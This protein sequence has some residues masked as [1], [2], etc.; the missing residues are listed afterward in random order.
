MSRVKEY[1]AI[2]AASAAIGTGIGYWSE[3]EGNEDAKGRVITVDTCMRLHKNENNVVT[4]ILEECME[5]GVPGGEPLGDKVDVNDPFEFVTSAR[6]HE[7][8]RSQFNVGRIAVYTVATPV[9]VTG[10]ILFG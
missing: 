6:E 7:V 5:D 8:E 4:K 1:L 10:Y 3:V 9:V 2:G